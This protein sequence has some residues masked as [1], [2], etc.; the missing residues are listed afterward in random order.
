MSE[1]Q[2]TEITVTNQAT[3][4]ALALTEVRDQVNLIQ[5]ILTDVMKP[6]YHYGVI[7]GCGDKPALLK[8]GAEKLILTFRLAP[9]YRIDRNAYQRD[10]IEYTISC[11]LTSISSGQFIGEGVGSCSTLESKFR[12]RNSDRKCPS[13]GKEGSIIKGKAEYGGG[14][15]CFN[16]KGG[17]GAKWADGA[18]EIE[19][20]Q[21]GKVEHDNPADYYNTVLKMAKKRALV[22]AVLTATAASDIFAQDIE[23][24]P[25]LFGGGNQAPPPQNQQQQ[26][27]PPAPAHWKDVM[28]PFG[29]NKGKH[30]GSLEGRS[31]NW[32][33]EECEGGGAQFQAWLDQARNERDARKGTPQKRPGFDPQQAPPADNGFV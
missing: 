25:E 3:G 30:L 14:W 4:G 26:Q 5:Q 18:M 27:A 33:L 23:D 28:V 29:T 7:P 8:P 21:P 15:L 11:R 17:C 22:D 12:Y 10:H 16:R 9:E 13:C 6:E 20:Q 32:Y 1:Q 19:G 31:L 2:S 24:N